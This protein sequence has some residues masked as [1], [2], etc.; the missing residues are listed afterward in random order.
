MTSAAEVASQQADELALRMRKHFAHKVL[1]ESDGAVTRIHTRFGPFELRPADGSLRIRATAPD[2]EALAH[3]EEV[4]V[5]H[6]ERFARGEEL[7]VRWA[8]EE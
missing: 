5:S 7:T 3:L 4:V 6:L 8:R 1:V 2:A